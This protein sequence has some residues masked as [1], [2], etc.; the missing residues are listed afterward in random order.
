MNILNT[1]VENKRTEVMKQKRRRP[2]SGIKDFS[3][4]KRETNR[5]DPVK[6][7]E[8]PGIIA[9]FKRRSPSKGAINE[10]A[11]PLDVAAGYRGAGVAAMS[12]LTDSRFFGGSFRDLLDVRNAFPDL[13]LLRK[14]FIIDPYQIHES[15]ACGADMVLLIASILE[16]SQVADLALEARKLGLQVLFEVHDGR[17]LEK[18]HPSIGFVGVNNR[19]LNTFRVD[20]GKSRELIQHMP[21]GITAVS[22]S[23][24]NGIHDIEA[25]WKSGFRLF[26]IGENLMVEKDPGVACKALIEQMIKKCTTQKK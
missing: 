23:G 13:A 14:D 22:E 26:L 3:C 12:I 17:E 15:S 19:D 8:C 6:L 18:Y 9:E 4:Y 24:I 16:R 21:E 10:Q 11:A 7:E 2:L 5:I 1:I 20:T 25:L